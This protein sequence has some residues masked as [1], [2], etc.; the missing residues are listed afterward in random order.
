MTETLPTPDL[1]TLPPLHPHRIEATLHALT[2]MRM[3]LTE[4]DLETCLYAL[5]SIHRTQ[6]AIGLTSEIATAFYKIVRQRR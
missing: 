6:Q 5:R 2:S 1:V 3:Q 4:K